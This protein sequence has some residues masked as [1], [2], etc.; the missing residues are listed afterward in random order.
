MENE[1]I[2]E[3][4]NNENFSFQIRMDILDI[5]FDIR[6]GARVICKKDHEV[7]EI[8]KFIIKLNLFISVGK[9]LVSI[10]A[11]KTG[12]N[13]DFKKSQNEIMQGIPLYIAKNQNYANDLRSY[14]E[15]GDDV[16]FGQLLSY[17][18]CCIAFVRKNKKVPT[19]IDAMHY[20]VENRK[21]NVWCWPV[22]SL[23]DA[24]LLPH[25]PCA[26]KC[27]SSQNLSQKRF[28][29]LVKYGSKDLINKIVKIHS[30]NY[31][32]ENDEIKITSEKD[33]YF[34][35]PNESLNEL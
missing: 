12:F 21:Y 9:G 4:I 23:S 7:E 32:F 16:K 28:K 26:N 24:S 6:K 2:Q 1:I 11:S 30:L 25:F 29:Y 22:A 8:V 33:I 13:D 5:F 34:V 20:L 10:L 15:S 14:D 18:E 19:L 35:S 27:A 31:Y 3:F 17:P